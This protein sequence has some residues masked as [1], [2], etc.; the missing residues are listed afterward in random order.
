MGVL[1]GRLKAISHVL[2]LTGSKCFVM[3]VQEE[4]TKAQ[5]VLVP[6]AKHS[7]RFLQTRPEVYL[8]RGISISEIIPIPGN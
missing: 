4:E 8:G 6:I 2:Y 3:D 1:E 5:L 7:F